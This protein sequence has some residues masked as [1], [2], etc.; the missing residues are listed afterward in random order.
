MEAQSGRR[1]SAMRRKPRYLSKDV[2]VAGQISWS[3]ED[4]FRP[5]EYATDGRSN[6]WIAKAILWSDLKF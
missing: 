5:L 6:A 1:T 3:P 2:A 4:I